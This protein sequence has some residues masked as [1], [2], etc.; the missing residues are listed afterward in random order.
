MTISPT[1]GRSLRPTA[2]NLESALSSIDCGS[3]ASRALQLLSGA[4]VH[5]AVSG[6]LRLEWRRM[7]WGATTVRRTAAAGLLVCLA[8]CGGVPSP[9]T[10]ATS[11]PARSTRG[12]VDP[13]GLITAGEVSAIVGARAEQVRVPGHPEVCLFAFELG[14]V[15]TGTAPTGPAAGRGEP[16]G[17]V[18]VQAISRSLVDRTVSSSPSPGVTLRR[19]ELPGADVAVELL[20]VHSNAVYL[21][22]GDVA[23]GVREQLGQ[24]PLDAASEERVARIVASHLP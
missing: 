16:T 2:W 15:P 1:A 14:G 3:G 17:Q 13:C 22:R 11:I 5:I 4:V 9:S 23:V 7:D 8:A 10:P 19:L 20:D 21:R 18:V 6:A 24:A 12:S